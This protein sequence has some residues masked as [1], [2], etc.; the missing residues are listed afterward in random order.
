[1]SIHL[2]RKETAIFR[3]LDRVSK[4]Y[5]AMTGQRMHLRVAGGWVRDKLLGLE[6]KDIDIAVDKMLGHEFA[7]LVKEDMASRDVKTK[8]IVRIAVNPEKSKHLETAIMNIMGVSIDFANLRSDVFD[9]SNR[10]SNDHVFGTPYEDAHYRDFTIN[11]LFY[12]IRNNSIEDYTGRGLDDLKN[13]LIRTPLNAIETFW[14]DP[15]RVLRCIRFA[16]RFQF[17]I[18]NDA[19]D[20]MQE[21]KIREALKSK[22][23]KERIGIEIVKILEDNV[24]RPTAI[25]LLRQLN[26]YDLVFTYPT[27][28]VLAKGT[29]DVFGERGDV[30]DAFK[31]AWIMEWLLKI[32]PITPQV[33]TSDTRSSEKSISSDRGIPPEKSVSPF[34]PERDA[35]QEQLLEQTQGHP[36]TSHLHAL[37]TTERPEE[38]YAISGMEGIFESSNVTRRLIL[39]SLLYPYYGVITT[40]NGKVVSGAVWICRYR[41]KV[42]LHDIEFIGTLQYN[43]EK[44][45]QIVK[46][47]NK[48]MALT[49]AEIEEEQQQQQ[50]Q[51]QEQQQQENHISEASSHSTDLTS[52]TTKHQ[53]GSRTSSMGN[54]IKRIG[55]T[56]PTGKDWPSMFL[57]GLGVELLPNYEQL[58]Q[59]V[60]DDDAKAK[61]AKYNTFLSKAEAYGIEHCYA[62]RHLVTIMGPS[63]YV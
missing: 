14:Q 20:A 60:L 25:R 4:D 58:K 52:S 53:E 8:P 29:S 39:S 61:I 21:P 43:L 16:G 37:V 15:L 7:A 62:W 13:G 18:A 49:E 47:L 22:V 24:A 55:S 45:K 6:S 40:T 10:F 63:D 48:D 50:Q 46:S 5:E 41:L 36:M 30:E 27:T 42:R 34:K 11:A 9:D 54:L 33:K 26:L 19:M 35:S 2:T 59:G 17:K 51:Q 57:F 44:V 1:M 38:A 28:S 32:N 12:N 56:L 31:L 3:I 23:S